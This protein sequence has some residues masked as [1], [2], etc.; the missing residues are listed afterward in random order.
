M[1]NLYFVQAA[2]S[3]DNFTVYLPYATGCLIAYAKQDAEIAESY[4]FND[5]LFMRE[6]IGDAI[7]AI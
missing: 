6:E 4:R 5:I 2:I 3:R 1:R 7:K